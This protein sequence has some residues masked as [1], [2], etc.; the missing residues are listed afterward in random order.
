MRSRRYIPMYRLL[1]EVIQVRWDRNDT[2]WLLTAAHIAAEYAPM[3]AWQRFLGHAGDPFRLSRRPGLH[4]VPA[5]DG[6]TLTTATVHNTKPVKAAAGRAIRVIR[7]A[8]DP[9]GATTSTGSTR[10]SRRR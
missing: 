3:L 8:A 7:R 2:M 6:D 4:A 5:A 1:L 10:W 9:A